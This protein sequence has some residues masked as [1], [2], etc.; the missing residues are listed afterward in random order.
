MNAL[1]V[2]CAVI[3]HLVRASTM[4][5]GMQ[6]GGMQ[7]GLLHPHTST[8]SKMGGDKQHRFGH[9]SSLP[10][11][12]SMPTA[13]V[14]ISSSA[15]QTMQV[16]AEFCSL[17]A[18]HTRADLVLLL[19]GPSAHQL[20]A[21]F[22][23]AFARLG[24]RV[25]IVKIPVK[26]S[27]VKYGMRLQLR[28]VVDQIH[29]WWDFVKLYAFALTQYK[30]VVLIDSDLL[31]R[32]NVDEL[33]EMED[34]THCNGSHS[35][36]NVGLVVLQPSLRAFR[37]LKSFVLSGDFTYRTFW[38][39]SGHELGN[40]SASSK[41]ASMY[42]AETTQGLLYYYYY[43]FL[44]RHTLID[45]NVYNYQGAEP[46]PRGVKVVHFT[47]CS[48]STKPTK[49]GLVLLDAVC[50]SFFRELAVHQLHAARLARLP[51]L[52]ADLLSH[53]MFSVNLAVD[54][55]GAAPAQENKV[56][57]RQSQWSSIEH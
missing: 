42:G 21:R 41:S 40:L 12:L 4:S 52:P 33:F 23:A 36:L 39:G 22:S 7:H 31:F 16:L 29:G 43:V 20:N 51:S 17:R 50:P 49:T 34:G 47:G 14:S 11:R 25:A 24:A 19:F 13:W 10:A 46:A 2:Y 44:G 30:K 57:S 1:T 55:S 32:E 27:D 53:Q 18:V 26:P 15:N 28:T 35:P 56:T 3:L 45:R 48:K 5:S 9:L 6:H 37:L 8:Q 38:R 54:Q